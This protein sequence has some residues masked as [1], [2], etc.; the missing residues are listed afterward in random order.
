M[1]AWVVL[2]GEGMSAQFLPV[3]RVD[4]A[5]SRDDGAPPFSWR[6]GVHS[7]S[8]AWCGARKIVTPIAASRSQRICAA[9]SCPDPIHPA[10]NPVFH[11]TNGDKKM[12]KEVN[13]E[14]PQ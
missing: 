6:T 8:P 7:P 3:C 11:S 13:T 12:T 2:S 10:A 9:I 4:R 14:E 5:A 1:T